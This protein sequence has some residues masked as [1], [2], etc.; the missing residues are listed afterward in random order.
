[1][2]NKD[3][4]L[5]IAIGAD[6]SGYIEQVNKI[7]KI[8]TALQTEMYS[9]GLSTTI[10]SREAI[11]MS[12]KMATEVETITSKMA[13]SI[14]KIHN[15]MNTDI[16]KDILNSEKVISEKRAKGVEKRIAEGKATTKE[17]ANDE[18]MLMLNAFS[19][20]NK[21]LEKS[22]NAQK[23][24]TK[25]ALKEIERVQRDSDNAVFTYRLNT[26]KKEKA[27]KEA[28][29]KKAYS[30]AWRDAH[31]HNNKLIADG[32][33]VATEN[34]KAFN[35]TMAGAVANG[36]TFMHKMYTTASYASAGAVIYGL[37]AALSAV[38]KES[39]AFDDA[40][41]SNMAVLN[42]S[43]KQATLLAENARDLS[44]VYGG[45]IKEIDEVTLTL[46]RA[47]V[48]YENLASAVKS[49]VELSTITGDSFSDTSKVVSSFVTNFKD[50]GITVDIMSDKLAYMANASKMSTEDLGT[51]ANYGL[52]TA[53]TLGLTIDTVGALA[54]TLS[55]LGI[56]ASTI[57][58]QMQKLDFIFTGSQSSISKFWDVLG[59]KQSDVF[60]NIKKG[61]EEGEKAILDFVKSI[62]KLSQ[63]DLITATQG[64]EINTKKLIFSLVN[65]S[66]MFEEHMIKISNSLDATVQAELKALSTTK[67]LE[68]TYNQLI[69]SADGVVTSMTDMFTNRDEALKAN[70]E[71]NKI[72]DTFSK[73]NESSA[74]YKET[75]K[76]LE[77][78]S[79]NVSKV[80]ADVN[81]NMETYV[82]VLAFS[83]RG[84]GALTTALG[85][86][87]I[88]QIAFNTTVSKNPYI[89]AAAAAWALYEAI[90]YIGNATDKQVKD[91]KLIEERY[92]AIAKNNE[93]FRNTEKAQI[94][95]LNRSLNIHYANLDRMSKLG[96]DTSGIEKAIKL[97][98]QKVAMVGKETKANKDLNM[99]T[100]EQYEYDVK[101]S[102]L[103]KEISGFN[104]SITEQYKEDVLI[105][106]QYLAETQG[107]TVEEDRRAAENKIKM[108]LLERELKYKKEL[109]ALSTK[110]ERKNKDRF[111]LAT[112]N[113][114]LSLE[115]E[116]AK[117]SGKRLTNLDI[118]NS[119]LAITNE[120]YEDELERVSLLTKASE[121]RA[122][123]INAELQLAKAKNGV[124]KEELA[125]KERELETY[126]KSQMAIADSNDHLQNANDIYAEREAVLDRVRFTLE[127][128]VESDEKRAQLNTLELEHTKN[129]SDLESGRF[130]EAE[131][132]Y[133][134]QKEHQETM[135]SMQEEFNNIFSSWGDGL[136]GVYGQIGD[137]SKAMMKMR[138]NEYN[139]T[140]KQG[141]LD[142]K[143]E[144]LFTASA[145]K[146]A[147]TKELVKNY[148]EEQIALKQEQFQVEM[149]GYSNVAGAMGSLFEQGS[150]E[151]KAFAVIQS[152]LAL[153]SGVT[154]ILEQGKGDPYTAF[155]RMAV[156]AATVAST[157]SQAGISFGAGVSTS[158]DSFSAQANNTGTGSVLGDTDKATESIKNSL[159]L[160]RDIAKPELRLISQMNDSLLSIDI[161]LAGTAA[162]LSRTSGYATG[163]G[164]TASSSSSG[165]YLSS[166]A[167]TAGSTALGA[168]SIG[169]SSAGLFLPT[170]GPVGLGVA[171]AP[172]GG[173]LL[174]NIIGK[175][176]VSDFIGG[177]T[178]FIGGI[179][180]SNTTYTL[181][182][183]GI[184]FGAQYIQTAMDDLIGQSFQTVLKSTRTSGLFSSSTSNSTY[185]TFAALDEQTNREFELILTN[186][187]DT[188]LIAT[189]GL[190]LA[191]SDIENDL[192]DFIVNIGKISLK[193]KTGEEI[194]QQLTD[195]FGK[196]GDELA[197]DALNETLNG[198]QQVGEGL[199]ETLV[200]VS[201]GMQE[202]EYYINR[203]G[204]S[205]EE[206]AYTDIINQ[207]G[208]VGFEALSQSIIKADEAM[209]GFDN[210]VVQMIETLD[211]SASDL[212][213]VYNSF[214][215]L[216]GQITA[217]GQ[218]AKYLTSQMLLGAGGVEAL[219]D[220]MTT[221]FD[222]V[223]DDGEK[224]TYMFNNMS[225]EFANLGLTLPKNIDEFQA[226]VNN[227]DLSTEAGQ[228][229]YGRVILLTDGFIELNNVF[230]NSLDN[231]KS[232]S[233]S[234]KTSEQLAFDMA[235]A[236]GAP[237]ATS[238]EEL[239]ML[240]EGL[241]LTG[242]MLTDAELELLNTN[243]ALLEANEELLQQNVADYINSITSSI[244][245]L[246]GVAGTLRSTIDKLREGSQISEQ[247]LTS[248]YE[249]M[250]EAQATSTGSDYDVFADAVTKATGLSSVLL[251]SSNFSSSRDMQF[252]Q[253]V[254]ANQFEALEA[255]TLEEIDYLKMI[256]DNTALINDSVLSSLSVKV[257]SGELDVI[258]MADILNLTTQQLTAMGLTTRVGELQVAKL[259]EV[260]GLSQTQINTLSAIDTKDGISLSSL[261]SLL[262]LTSSQNATLGLMTTNDLEQFSTIKSIDDETTAQSGSFDL[263]AQLSESQKS[264]LNTLSSTQATNRTLS[265]VEAWIKA[266]YEAQ[267]NVNALNAVKLSSSSFTAGHVFGTQENIDFAKAT[268]LTIGSDAFNTA[269]R[270]IQG[271]STKTAS[272]DIAHLGTLGTSSASAV[273]SLDRLKLL[274]SDIPQAI[275]MYNVEKAKTYNLEMGKYSEAR[276]KAN[277]AQYLLNTLSPHGS[278]PNAYNGSKN[279]AYDD[280]LITEFGGS[281]PVAY[282]RNGTVRMVT[283]LEDSS[284]ERVIGDFNNMPRPVY[285]AFSSGGYTGDMSPSSVAG[286]VHGQ[287]YVVNA[288]T[289]KQLGLNS[290]NGGIFKEMLEQN[291]QMKSL[292]ISIAASN[293][294]ILSTDRAMLGSL[295]S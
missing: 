51:F 229:L 225:R 293:E 176:F 24:L 78:A 94:E 205:F 48:E 87:K 227:I 241:T 35:K 3:E 186:L 54:T 12:K 70:D 180:G 62:S 109:R 132:F 82:D 204:G 261:S 255:T 249:A 195:V 134:A 289:T 184:T 224:F 280:S 177:I 129:I 23:T 212:Y 13:S 274:P 9:K 232:W 84:L 203:L 213:E 156:M 236:L 85:I 116:L 108:Q 231:I 234:F 266:L 67:L 270:D 199:F 284:L 124:T 105:L 238:F 98:K 2:A 63:D 257:E 218:D 243:K 68:K 7:K 77:E 194:Q 113:A 174:E 166:G 44:M 168:T 38:T 283:W 5:L 143:Y 210:G 128:M 272:Q 145:G 179:G 157:L 136:S 56:N 102:R 45:Q 285:N 89:I 193:D 185:S 290:N 17:V 121:Q 46:G 130:K 49:V 42:L 86:A 19:E 265:S 161:A 191:A 88:A 287:E 20:K 181:K 197:A 59:Q 91:A 226:L 164:F 99:I 206:I 15:K 237:L 211:A 137:I 100:A 110:E 37:G 153:V 169:I 66:T 4:E 154:A 142:S 264:I 55:N 150:R 228:E 248:F 201:G 1:M 295:V 277:K 64:M 189:N 96:K 115:E 114:M 215:N 165:G 217:T 126:F 276:D 43:S 182:D 106:K 252:A 260:L 50:A 239:T 30:I 144:K 240:A 122:G 53:K 118:A 208:D 40:I 223:L 135:L 112:A 222:T 202:A 187:Y 125:L 275:T 167:F 107:I 188:V 221:F 28:E 71:Y 74:N 149:Q 18:I 75:Q 27:R 242:G 267:A 93:A 292:L 21:L 158:S 162:N 253:L 127:G 83:A 6:I 178:S 183:A 235:V 111:D 14:I 269:I 139:A 26:Y 173:Q 47:G 32:K 103:K 230:Q 146:E 148:T 117:Y 220:G 97:I 8:Y 151:A 282:S 11:A 119:K 34:T 288:P 207:Q 192:S 233:D 39:L 279:S 22:L 244:S 41:Y 73:M 141:A 163:E 133:E 155:A 25:K 57:G 69:T 216:R 10:N 281:Y 159:E 131:E 190:D 259:A 52:Q 200:R 268:G 278:F 209:Y 198:F 250:R 172:L 247:S 152:G 286:I 263:L 214:E 61:G 76:K 175:N 90:S 36:T 29:D 251:D 81:A 72:L 160:L 65:G 120:W 16:A 170:L 138:T 95:S 101:T 271:F 246:E 294:K 219:S 171:L 104:T 140:K 256:A 80:V 60:G 258:G 79:K 147:E 58:T 254:A 245:K 196:I 33:R 92:T 31:E 123:F 273:K 291:Q 262:G